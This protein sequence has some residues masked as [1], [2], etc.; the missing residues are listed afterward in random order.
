M[1]APDLEYMYIYAYVKA[2]TAA[3]HVSFP[4]LTWSRSPWVYILSWREQYDCLIELP[5]LKISNF[6]FQYPYFVS[7]K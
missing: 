6:N 4:Y 7:F 2:G 1:A 3:S 5:L